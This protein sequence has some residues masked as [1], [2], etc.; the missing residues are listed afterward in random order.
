MVKIKNVG[1]VAGNSHIF[2]VL[3]IIAGVAGAL[4]RPGPILLGT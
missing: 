4:S 1:F 3:W 2:P